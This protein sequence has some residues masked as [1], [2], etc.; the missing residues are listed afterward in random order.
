MS[1]ENNLFI[2]CF[3]FFKVKKLDTY[4]VEHLRDVFL[5]KNQK[6]IFFFLFFKCLCLNLLLFFVCF[7]RK[8]C[9]HRPKF[10]PI[11]KVLKIAEID[12]SVSVLAEMSADTEA[13]NFRL[14]VTMD[15][16]IWNVLISMVHLWTTILILMN[17]LI[18]EVELSEFKNEPF[19]KG[20]DW[21]L[22]IMGNYW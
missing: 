7:C 15:I 20:I 10:R 14:L 11:P 6:W 22:L 2:V 3:E 17:Q 5:L 19:G 18:V 1:Y 4:K 8:I 13:E 12:I 21:C 16:E 9:I